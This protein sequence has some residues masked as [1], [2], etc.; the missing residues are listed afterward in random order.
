MLSD[1]LGFTYATWHGDDA[2]TNLVNEL[3]QLARRYESDGNHAVLIALDG[4]NAWEHYPFNGFYFLR[5]LY[6]Q[7]AEHPQLELMTLSE[8]L[9][10]DIRPAPLPR[11][12]AGSWVHGTLAT[13]MGDAAK[14]RAWDLLCDAK[15]AYDRVMPGLTDPAQRAA[16]GRQLAL[17]ESSDWFWWFGDYNPADAVSQFDRLYRRQLL[18]LYRRLNLAPPGELAQP[19]SEGYGAPEHGGAMRRATAG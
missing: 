2:A 10:R 11:V 16:A 9:A 18:A 1:L 19:I 15:L 7:L 6:E 8:C 13:W 12:C 17:C 5:A 4:E 14:N 3:L